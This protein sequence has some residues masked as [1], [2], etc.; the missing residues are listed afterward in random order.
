MENLNKKLEDWA[1]IR[2]E[3]SEASKNMFHAAS[4]MPTIAEIPDVAAS[5][6][7]LQEI[8]S[9]ASRV[10]TAE[11]AALLTGESA[12]GMEVQEEAEIVESE[13]EL[14][15][16]T[17][18]KADAKTSRAK[19]APFRQAASPNKVANQTL[20]VKQQKATPPA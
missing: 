19:L 5:M 4:H 10:E 2:S 18:D 3:V 7:R 16:E 15:S 6:Q 9:S 1:K 11:M 17:G 13:P 14:L 8:A 12:E 20:K